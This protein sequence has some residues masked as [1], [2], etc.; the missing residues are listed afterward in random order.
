MTLS[1]VPLA[2]AMRCSACWRVGPPGGSNARSGPTCWSSQS[3]IAAESISVVPSA[4]TSEGTRPSGFVVR[5]ELKSPN[6][7]RVSCSKSKPSMWRLTATR[8]V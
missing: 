4:R 6:T 5:R 2:R 7:E 8:R 3:R 1:M